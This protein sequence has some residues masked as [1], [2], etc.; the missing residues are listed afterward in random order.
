MGCLD[1]V[2]GIILAIIAVIVGIVFLFNPGWTIGIPVII[3]GIVF[4]IMTLSVDYED[5]MSFTDA[6]TESPLSGLMFKYFIDAAVSGVV[7][8]VV[9]LIIA[10]LCSL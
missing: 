10:A 1:K 3:G 6:L 7:A 4:G 2:G 5:F 8:F 9:Y